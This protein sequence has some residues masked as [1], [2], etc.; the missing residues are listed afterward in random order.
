MKGNK[1]SS[2]GTSLYQPAV[3]EHIEITVIITT[4]ERPDL[5]KTS[6][7]SVLSQTVPPLEIIIIND[8]SDANY[9]PVLSDFQQHN[10]KYLCLDKRSGANVARN[11]GV[12]AAKG[13]VIAF[14]D[15]DDAWLDTFLEKHIQMYL[16]IPDTGAVICGHRI[17]QSPNRI[18]IN[19]E[20]R[21][22]ANELRHGNR[23]SGMSGFS[24]KTSILRNYPFD[25][26][27]KNGQ[28]WDL[29]VRLI[30]NKIKFINIP[31][32]LFL[33]REDTPGSISAKVIN[34][35]ATDAEER[36]QS[37]IKHRDWLGEKFYKKR[38]SEQVLSLISHKSNKLAWLR[39]S[40]ELAGL[41]ATLK[42][43]IQQIKR[44]LKH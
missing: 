41:L 8:C 3:S 33:Y 9:Q 21:V 18:N 1:G 27:L 29:F 34:M 20:L 15:D 10:I 4:F 30:Q 17:M 43:V 38:V 32:P 5:L 44:K 37:S 36:L 13:T 24:A 42:T 12:Q 2:V 19:P 22:S 26:T 28:D 40:I 39:K 14:L 25:P 11:I 6:L 23:F 31:K 7:Q 35:Q 16:Q